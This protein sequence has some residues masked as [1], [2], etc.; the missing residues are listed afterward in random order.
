MIET[1]IN[2]LRWR[3]IEWLNKPEYIYLP[4]FY[5][6]LEKLTARK[7]YIDEVRTLQ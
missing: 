1:L 7:H 3:L 4:S 6:S 5:D 2:N